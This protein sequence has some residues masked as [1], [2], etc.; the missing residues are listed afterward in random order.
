M[1]ST[2]VGKALEG[3]SEIEQVIVLYLDESLPSIQQFSL[4][5]IRAR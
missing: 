5:Y 4:G 3:K 2:E 1:G